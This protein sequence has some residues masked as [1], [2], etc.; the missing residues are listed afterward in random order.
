LRNVSDHEALVGSSWTSTKSSANGADGIGDAI[1]LLFDSDDDI[2]MDSSI[3]VDVDTLSV[4]IVCLFIHATICFVRPAAD[5]QILLQCVQVCP[6]VTLRISPLLFEDEEEAS[7]EE[8]PHL[9]K[10][11]VRPEIVL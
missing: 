2:V 5:L 10:C 1:V 9:L 3:T 11:L 4:D 8:F 7:S 6:T